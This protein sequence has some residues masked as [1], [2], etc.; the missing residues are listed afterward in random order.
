VAQ[1]VFEAGKKHVQGDT[2]REAA[3]SEVGD[4]KNENDHLKQLGA[5]PL[6]RNRVLKKV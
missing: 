4:L 2:V 5:E 3:T 1:R 6:L